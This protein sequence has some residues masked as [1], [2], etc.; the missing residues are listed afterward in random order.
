MVSRG[1]HRL[2]AELVHKQRATA[3]GAKPCRSRACVQ[4]A[5]DHAET[6]SGLN[7]VSRPTNTAAAAAPAAAGE[8]IATERPRQS[9]SAGHQRRQQR[10]P[11]RRAWPK[12]RRI[13]PSDCKPGSSNP[14]RPTPA[15]GQRLWARVHGTEAAQAPCANASQEPVEPAPEDHRDANSMARSPACL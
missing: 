1:H 14:D 7:S 3:S 13:R 10:Q 2:P 5:A 6:C 4:S 11:R 9:G 12:R 15:A 8:A